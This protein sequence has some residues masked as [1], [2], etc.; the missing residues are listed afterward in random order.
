MTLYKIKKYKP[1]TRILIAF[2]FLISTY[3]S[4]SQSCKYDLDEYDKFQKVR[5]IE[6]TIKVV[7]KFNRGNGYLDLELCKYGD[8]FFYRVYTASDNNIVVGTHDEMIFLLDNNETIKATPEQIYSADYDGARYLF[9]GTYHFSGSDSEKLKTN[10][11]KSIR[12]YFNNVYKDF[13]VKDKKQ[14][15]LQEAAKCF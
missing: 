7:K 14:D 13:E 4:F 2:T 15:E 3:T 12:L 9:E 1:M 8:D 6:K 5:K 10:K 11:V